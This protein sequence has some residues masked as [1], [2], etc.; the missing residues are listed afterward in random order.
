VRLDFRLSDDPAG[1]GTRLALG[2]GRSV[3]RQVWLDRLGPDRAAHALAMVQRYGLSD[4]IA[5]L[6]VGRGVTHAKVE[7]HLD[8][9]IRT[10]MPDPDT[11]RDLPQAV[12]RLER[13][14][15]DRETVAIF[16]DYDVDGAASSALMASF[17]EACG[18]H[19]TVHIPDRIIEGY[20]PNTEA[21]RTFARSGNTLLITVDCGSTSFE[22]LAHAAAL[23][24]ETIVIDHH[25]VAAELPSAIAVVNPNR[26]DD[27]SGLGHLSAAGVAYMVLVG[28]NRALRQR[29]FWQRRVQPDLLGDLDLVALATIADLVPLTDLN[30]A[31]VATGLQVM[32]ARRRPGLTAL[33][34][35]VGGEGPP[36]PYHLGFLVGPRINA[37][38]RIGDAS[39]GAR[40]LLEHDPLRAQ[41]MALELDRL[42][43]ERQRIE[44]TAVE[45]AEVGAAAMLAED[46]SVLVCCA[47]S[48]HPGVVGLVASRLKERFRRPAFA[49][50][51]MGT[52][53]I[54][55]GRSVIGIDLGRAV[56]AAVEAGLLMK[57][58][59]HAMAAGITI[60]SDRIDA[61]RSFL[62]D[63]FRKGMQQFRRTDALLIDATLA[64]S[65]ATAALAADIE[66]TGPFG[67]GNPEPIFAFPALRIDDASPI[68][69]GHVRLRARSIDGA[70]LSGIAFRCVGTPLGGALL[71]AR[72]GQALHLAGSLTIDHWGRGDRVQLRIVDAADPN[73]RGV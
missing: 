70:S 66:R 5:R 73:E 71:A 54:G 9:K 19:T 45:E 42:N 59:G 43:R 44:A 25:R 26:H 48:W 32:R 68:G 64:A 65:G 12:A 49:I 46:S 37:G 8:P 39:L 53:G 7:S 20:G 28:L 6:L 34:D 35:V 23:G 13:A 58:G 60:G 55:S 52:V 50:S 51:L 63:Y 69:N 41:Q 14:V 16:G 57:G 27:L 4:L 67:S 62:D 29:G 2:V 33:L 21:I 3:L 15:L 40:L 11:L 22:P 56:S 31:F 24:L 30:R 18:C 17:L 36:R 10:L 38:G 1:R 47:P 61:F 72:K